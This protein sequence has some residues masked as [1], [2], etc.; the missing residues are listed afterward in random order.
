V[1]SSQTPGVA[2]TLPSAFV[3]A[4]TPEQLARRSAAAVVLL[5][6]WERDAGSDQDQRDTM[7][8]LRQALGSDRVGSDR[9][10]IVP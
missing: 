4:L 3:P 6:E 10:A 7:D 5:D 8:V 9:P 2:E 1:I